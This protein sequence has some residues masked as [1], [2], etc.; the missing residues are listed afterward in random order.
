[1]K[2]FITCICIISIYNISIAQNTLNLKNKYSRKELKDIY[3]GGKFYDANTIVEKINYYKYNSNIDTVPIKDLI[4]G[5]LDAI[6]DL[7]QYLQGADGAIKDLN[8][9]KFFTYPKDYFFVD[10]NKDNKEDLIFKSRGPSSNS[11]TEYFALFIS[12]KTTKKYEVFWFFHSQLTNIS[13]YKLQF[14]GDK[15]PVDGVIIDYIKN[16]CCAEVGW[17][18]FKT[19]FIRTDGKFTKNKKTILRKIHTNSI[20][21]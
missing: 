7:T 11:D 5:E 17:D 18:Y 6:L 15:K 19:D 8:R 20:D 12:N 14:P 1:M 4:G 10:I 16:G 13:N 21:Y 9:S 3:T 2:F